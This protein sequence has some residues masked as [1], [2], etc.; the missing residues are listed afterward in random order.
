MNYDVIILGDRTCSGIGDWRI[1]SEHP[2]TKAARV[3]KSSGIHGW[4][5][6]DKDGVISMSATGTLYL[7]GIP[8]KP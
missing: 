1:I 8:E 4:L 7:N 3:V 2:S 5:S 6:S